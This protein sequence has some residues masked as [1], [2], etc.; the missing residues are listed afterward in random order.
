ML[1]SVIS[2]LKKQLKFHAMQTIN[3]STNVAFVTWNLHLILTC[4]YFID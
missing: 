2:L 1:A 4:K 3:F